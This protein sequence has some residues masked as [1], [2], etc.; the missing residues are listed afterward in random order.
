MFYI[1]DIFFCQDTH[2]STMRAIAAL[3]QDTTNMDHMAQQGVLQE[4]AECVK[5]FPNNVRITNGIWFALHM[6]D[7]YLYLIVCSNH[8]AC[9]SF[10]CLHFCFTLFLSVLLLLLLFLSA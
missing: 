4:L 3:A 2:I 8:T 9:V 7:I 6:D 10:L 1:V 5:R